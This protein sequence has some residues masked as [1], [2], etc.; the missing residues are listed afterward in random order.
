VFATSEVIYN[1][2]SMFTPAGWL[3]VLLFT[4]APADGHIRW[5]FSS[6]KQSKSEWKLVFSAKV[7]KG[8]HLYSQNLE[9]DG[10][11]P[12]VFKFAT[13]DKFKLLGNVNEAGVAK[14]VYDSTF[15]MNVV[16][17]E[18]EVLFTQRVKVKSDVKVTG[19]INYSVCS[20]E[21]CIPGT[22]RFSIDVG[23]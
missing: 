13:D 22:V 8:W 21:R 6:V 11:M 9:E 19:E 2:Q 17:Y 5:D 1:Q 23:R 15:M 4:S 12:T 18:S 20:E 3:L 10:P 16:W 14:T 7:D